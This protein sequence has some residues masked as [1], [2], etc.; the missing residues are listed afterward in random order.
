[1]RFVFD[2]ANEAPPTEQDLRVSKRAA[3]ILSE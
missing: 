2:L 1:M 3:E